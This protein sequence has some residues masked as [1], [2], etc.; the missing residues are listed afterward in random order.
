MQ[1]RLVEL[2]ADGT[3]SVAVRDGDRWVPLAPLSEEPWA[4]DV[5]ALL[6]GGEQVRAGA[7]ELASAATDPAPFAERPL[8]PFAARSFRD[9][10]I[11]PEHLEGSARTLAKRFFPAPAG[12]AIGAFERATGKTFPALKPK[13]SMLERPAYYMGNHTAFVTDGETAPWPAYTDFLDYELELGFVIARPVADATPA[14]GEAAI[15]ALM[16]VNDWSARDTQAD[17]YRHGVFG[18]VIK[19]KSFCNSMGHVLVTA[20]ELLGRWDSLSASVK[21]DGEV[22]SQTSTAGSPHSLG[23]LVA[24]ASEGERLDLGDVLATGTL[25]RGCGLELDRWVKPGDVVE[26]EI[27]GLGTLSNP[28]GSRA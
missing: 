3:R 4:S 15:G 28:I 12:A 14:E 9:F 21:V 1:L 17:E 22:W 20:D 6:A 8:L 19:T 24:R 27:E 7:A 5:L 23:D 25:P 10:S 2:E 11:Y 16:I 13:A 18:P 26:L